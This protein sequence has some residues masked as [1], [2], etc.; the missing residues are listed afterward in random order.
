MALSPRFWQRRF[1]G[2]ID[3]L[4]LTTAL[5]NQ[6]ARELPRHSPRLSIYSSAARQQTLSGKCWRRAIAPLAPRLRP[7]ESTT[8]ASLQLVRKFRAPQSRYPS[9]GPSLTR[10]ST[11]STGICSLVPI[12]V[13]GE[14]YIG[15]DGLA[16]G[17]LDQPGLTAER[18]VPTRSVAS[19]VGDSTRPVT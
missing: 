3:T 18:F 8:F 1:A 13:T 7:D 14:L 9:G 2:G 17:Y 16:R 5:F 6:I 11:S 4:F 10:G 19:R 12:G 15:G